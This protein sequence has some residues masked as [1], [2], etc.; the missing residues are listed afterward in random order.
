ML[1]CYL[2]LISS[3]YERSFTTELSSRKAAYGI[4]IPIR[5]RIL[6]YNEDDC[7]PTRVLLDGIR[8]LS[9]R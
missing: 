5:Q 2:P 6:D 1:C 9:E 3:P 4:G 7:R 8:G